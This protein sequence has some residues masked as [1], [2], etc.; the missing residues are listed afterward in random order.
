M[1][2]LA[3]FRIV[4]GVPVEAKDK[5]L[6]VLDNGAKAMRAAAWARSLHQ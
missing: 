6:P 4:F 3:R 1:P 5:V 2:T